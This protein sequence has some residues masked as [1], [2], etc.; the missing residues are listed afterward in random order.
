VGTH[1]ERADINSFLGDSIVD[2]RR[3]SGWEVESRGCRVILRLSDNGRFF[4][5]QG[6]PLSRE[7]VERTLLI[8]R[9]CARMV[10]E[11]LLG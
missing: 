8:A 6:D 7:V 3:S 5:G 9:R 4:Q 10:M 1:V 2:S 11:V